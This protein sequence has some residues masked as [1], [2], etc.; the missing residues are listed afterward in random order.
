MGRFWKSIIRLAILLCFVPFGTDA[1][2]MDMDTTGIEETAFDIQHA[3]MFFGMDFMISV[4]ILQSHASLKKP[5]FGFHTQYLFQPDKSKPLFTGVSLSIGQY[6]SESIEYYDFV[7]FEENLFRETTH[8]DL[9]EINLKGRYFPGLGFSVFE[10]FVDLGAGFRNSFGYTEVLNV[11]YDENVSTRL[12]DS[13]WSLGYSLGIGTLFRF[14]Q[15]SNTGPDAYG[16]FALNYSG[17]ENS[18]FYLAKPDVDGEAN[19]VDRFTWRSIPFQVLRFN[20]G[21]ILY[22]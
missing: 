12:E 1:Q 2:E 21:L 7:E 9:L 13:D 16:H 19:P 20:T 10:P 8:C 4:P 15:A 6:D 3:G 18:F 17:G 5:V 14:G 11:D 22:F